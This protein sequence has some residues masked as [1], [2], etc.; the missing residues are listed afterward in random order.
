M[1]PPPVRPS[2]LFHL[3]LLLISN[4][5]AQRRGIRERTEYLQKENILLEHSQPNSLEHTHSRS[6][7]KIFNLEP[8]WAA[9]N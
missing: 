2:V 5:I 8:F 3:M 6:F 1:V 9:D 4:T 7:S